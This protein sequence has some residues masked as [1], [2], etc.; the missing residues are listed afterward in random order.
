VPVQYAQGGY[1]ASYGTYE[2]DER[3]HT[4]KY[5]VDGGL[6]RTLIGKDLTRVYEL[7][8]DQLIVES[9]NP[10]EHRRV[11]RSDR[12]GVK[13]VRRSTILRA[14]PATR[15]RTAT[16]AAWSRCL[17]LATYRRPFFPP[18]LAYSRQAELRMM[19]QKL[20][21]LNVGSSNAS[22]SSFIV[23]KVVSGLWPNP[24]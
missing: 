15:A 24:S 4:F 23:P 3:A 7:S 19:L 22:T 13:G 1:K 10:N 12:R 18:P 2:I 17:R 14:N 5:H 6:V 21:R 16:W 9:S 20:A 8:G 11:R